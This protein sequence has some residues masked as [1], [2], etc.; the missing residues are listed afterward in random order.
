MNK[1]SGLMTRFAMLA[2]IAVGA[3]TP[4][5]AYDFEVRGSLPWTGW[6]NWCAPAPVGCGGDYEWVLSRLPATINGDIVTIAPHTWVTTN[7]GWLAGSANMDAVLFVE[8]HGLA[9]QSVTFS[10]V[11]LFNTL[12]SPYVATAFVRDFDAFGGYTF[13]ESKVNLVGGERFRVTR[14]IS[15]ADGHF[16][17]VGFETN[18]PNA[19]PDGVALLGS[20]QVAPADPSVLFPKLLAD[21]AGVGPGTSLADKAILAQVYHDVP[22]V[23]AS[24]GVLTG[25]INQVRA[26]QHKKVTPKMLADQL[27]SEAKAIKVVIGCK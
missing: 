14:T 18:G 1:V 26:Q 17:E 13:Q 12:A 20:V 7:K 8:D 16:V 25:F 24:C 3:N 4:S 27:I 10:G 6:L 21:V 23:E 19:D 22:D 9:G 15:G 5:F 11:V 2:L